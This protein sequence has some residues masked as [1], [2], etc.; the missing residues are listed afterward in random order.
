MAVIS[1]DDVPKEIDL[2]KKIITRFPPEPNGYLHIGHLKSMMI[3]F[4]LPHLSEKGGEC[5]LRFDDTNP[6]TEKMEYV[7]KALEVIKW[8]EFKPS[9][10]TFASDYF[11]KM[12][13][14]AEK[15]IIQGDA[16]V[17]E[18]SKEEISRYRKEKIPSPFRNRTPEEN[19]E[20]FRKMKNGNFPDNSL[21]L[22]MKGDLES[23]SPCMWD[24]V[25]YRI[26]QKEHY[27]TGKD[28]IIYPSYDFAHCIVDALE[29]I[30]YSLCTTEFI[31]R[32]E[33]YYWLL[34]K[35][36]LHRPQIY[37][38]SK[39][40]ITHNILSK[41]KIKKL[42]DD[43]IVKGW[44]DPRLLTLMGL[45][46][47]GY[48]PRT[49][50]KAV[51]A[52]GYGKT[53]GTISMD[54]LEHEMRNYCDIF[55]KRKLAVCNPL[56]IIIVDG[57]ELLESLNC[58]LYDYPKYMRDLKEGNLDKVPKEFRSTRKMELTKII[59]I[60]HKDFRYVDSKKYFGLSTNKIV[61]LR[62]GPF[63]K[64]IGSMRNKDGSPLELYCKII[65]P[66]NPKKVKGILGWVNDKAEK[67]KFTRVKRLFEL[68]YPEEMED[69]K[70]KEDSLISFMGL[71]EP[72]INSSEKDHTFQFERIGFFKEQSDSYSKIKEFIEVVPLKS[73]KK[74]IDL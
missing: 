68:E 2:C 30:T 24:L 15:L 61:R 21:T 28:W 58:E 49:L 72:N 39:F 51:S 6:E 1:Q 63:I 65:I 70:A 13:D 56:K 10:I 74:L 62:Y 57:F 31:T 25:F 26:N 22:R 14:L 59:Y 47:R 40:N 37:E 42:V 32:R 27:R 17:C 9:K 16:Y 7:N 44:G 8:L 5:I 54:L 11:K 41:R 23:P 20:L 52:S 66:E 29:N 64:C 71:A 3:N 18:L 36:G 67:V 33:S 50:M 55:N 38:F 43:K 45:R 19:L 48:I 46:E 35:L 69:L 53:D 34:N 73:T 60:D 4:S 12:Y